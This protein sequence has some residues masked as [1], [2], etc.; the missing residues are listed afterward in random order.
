MKNP[1]RNEDGSIDIPLDEIINVIDG[2][3]VEDNIL[4]LF[5]YKKIM[6]RVDDNEKILHIDTVEDEL[7]ITPDDIIQ[8][9][10]VFYVMGSEG[11]YNPNKYQGLYYD[12]EYGF[13]STL[14]DYHY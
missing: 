2:K 11:I 3:D 12:W 14:R 6:L 7:R 13:T 4:K 5:T 8:S 9:E 1:I 10:E